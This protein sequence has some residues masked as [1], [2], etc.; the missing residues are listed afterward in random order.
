MEKYGLESYYSAVNAIVTLVV[1][2]MFIKGKLE[3]YN[4]VIDTN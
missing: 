1:E 2:Y 3:V 4:F